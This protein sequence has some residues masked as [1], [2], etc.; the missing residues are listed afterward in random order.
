M[1]NVGKFTNK[2]KKIKIK[3]KPKIWCMR[4]DEDISIL[5]LSAKNKAPE[6]R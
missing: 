2:K 5:T 1:P 6:M 3:L 4:Y